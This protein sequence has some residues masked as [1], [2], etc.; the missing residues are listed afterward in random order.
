MKTTCK[1]WGLSLLALFMS[2]L[3]ATA[4]IKVHTIG[5]STMADYDENSTDKRGWCQM[6]QQFFDAS[7]VIINNRGKSGASSKSFYLEAPYWKTVIAGVNAGDYVLIQFAHNDEKN[8]GLD[9]D[10][11]IA[12]AKANGESSDG[13][14]YRGTTA[15]G[16]FKKYIR[17]YIDETKAKGG[18]PIIVTPICRKYFNGSTIRRNGMHDL[19]DSFSILGSTNKGSVPESDN[20]HDYAQALRDVAA[21]YEDIPVIDLTLMTRDMYLSYGESYC[22]ENLFCSG[23]NTHPA[24]MGATLIARLA[25]QEMK[26][27][28]ILADHII[29]GTDITFSPTTGDFG[30]GYTG[31]TLTKE[32]NVSAFGLASQKGTFTFTVSKGFEVSTD[33]VN[34]AQNVTADYTAGN[35]ITTV[36]IRTTFAS[37]GTTTGTLTATDGTVN[38]ELSLTAECVNLNG[39]EEVSLLWPLT[40]DANPVATGPCTAVEETWTGMELQK[41]SSINNKAVWPAESGRDTSHQTQRNVIEG[42]EWPAGEIDEVSTRY[43]QFG[44]TAPTETTIDIDK[45]SL[46]VAGAGGSGMR[47]K[48]YYATDADFSDAT[49]IQEFSSMA[50]NTVYPVEA[51]PVVSIKDGQSLYLRI[52]PWYSSAATGKTICLSDVYIHGMAKKAGETVENQQGTITFPFE[53]GTEGQTGSYSEGANT[54]FKNNYVEVGKR[55]AYAGVKS[56]GGVTGTGF[57]PSNSNEGSANDDNRVDFI[58]IPKNGLAFIPTKVSF[59][60]TRHGTDGGK[61]DVSWINADGTIISLQKG[62]APAR[63]NAATPVTSVSCDVTGAPASDGPCGLRLNLYSLGNTKQVSFANIVIEGLVN[64]KAVELPQYILNATLEDEAAGELSLKPNAYVFTEGDEVTLTV[65]ENF[66]YHFAAWV[67][68]KGETVSTEN[69]YTLTMTADTKLT[70]RFDKSN[71]YAL[72]LKVIDDM[73]NSYGNA[74]L[75][76]ISPE[77]YVINGIHHYEKGTD[78]KLTVNNN[79]I[80][81]FTGWEDKSTNAERIIRM[82]GEKNLTVNYAVA[83][84]I[85]GW[86]LYLDEPKSNRA[87]DYR[88]SSENAGMLSLRKTDGTTSSWLTR[89]VNNGAEEGRWGARIWRKLSEGWYWEISFSTKGYSHITLSNGFGHSYN[90]YAVMRAEYSMDGTNFTK[91]GTYDIPVRGWVDGKFT[92]PAEANNQERIWIRW[93]GDTEE[94]TGVTGDYDGLTIGDIFVLGESEQTNDEVAPVL[95]NSNPENNATGTSANGSIVLTFDERIKAGSGVATLNSEEIVPIVNGKTAVFQYIGL[96]YNTQYT[97]TLPA[98]VI[99]DR[100]GNAYEGTTLTFTTMERTQ[101][102]VR[103]YDAVVATDGT[104][105]YTSVQAAIDAAPEGRAMPWLIFIKNGEYKGHVDIPANKPYLHFIGQERDKVIITDD[106]LCGGDNALHVSVGATVVVKSNDCYFDNLTLENSYGHDKQAGPQALA[107]NTMG[108]RTVFKNVAMLSY[109]DTWITPSTSNYRVY[110][111]D[112]FIEG[113]VDFIYNSGNIYIDNATIYINRKSG[114]YIVAPSH[115]ADVEWGYVFM[116]CRITAPSVPSETDVW[117]GRPWH[118]NPKT[119]FINTI[120]EV[121]IPAKGWYPTMGGLPVLWA[122]YNTMDAHGNPVDLS[123]R[124]DTYYY[125]DSNTGEKVY[126]KA[127]NYLTAEE[128]AQYTVKNVLSG[129][130]NWQPA[131]I[132]ESCAAPVATLSDDKSTITWETVPYAICYVIVKNGKEVEFTTATNI[133]AEEGANYMVYAANEQGGLSAGCGPNAANIESITNI[134]DTQTVAIYSVNGMKLKDFRPGINILKRM[135]AKG[136]ITTHK[137]VK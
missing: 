23:D 36:Y 41:Y 109:Q 86:D 18:K 29:V 113:A 72:N 100:N 50:G 30:K 55:L 102:T 69:P 95:M 122:D 74:N 106:K 14:D 24:K 49:L 127:K 34:Y 59:Q 32:F 85:V 88:S 114:G 62:I 103:L 92:L 51:I 48:I 1:H 116:N 75:V 98:G 52:Y 70:A 27:Q 57:Q 89:G 119:V 121:T 134:T 120:A 8:G 81:S 4:A 82:D 104:G 91:L 64:G 128:A 44:M 93:I 66:G 107:L 19:G 38:R 10:D 20:T 133:A 45:I 90:T 7:E 110:A 77:G 11:V 84:Y 12:H 112:C 47:C 137:V 26:A 73:E 108:D 16:T 71:V 65:S 61:V 78:V 97:F 54:W 3:T 2:A 6:L 42:G 31:Q 37:P 17:A 124:E 117:L 115:G 60:T 125:T 76:T 136:N 131:I 126:G 118:N 130:D 129:K 99:T 63:N 43:I 105:D 5:D 28:G 67:N 9:G 35:L 46:Y 80:L 96:D 79:K 94:L 53:K 132:T 22:T 83:D 111:K 101:P 25:A 68:E 58:I 123:Q 87:A 56:A 15:S 13:I 40:A 39:G 33:K 135:D 21:E